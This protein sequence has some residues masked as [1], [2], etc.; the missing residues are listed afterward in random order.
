MKTFWLAAMLVT[1]GCSREDLYAQSTFTENVSAAYADCNESE[2][3]FL[4]GKHNIQTAFGRC[5]SN[6]FIDTA[7]SPDGSK[8]H[9]RVTNGSFILNADDK[10]ISTVPTEVPTADSAWLHADL[11]AMPLIPEEG[12]A[13]DEMRMA[14]YNLSANTLN[15]V[16]LPATK[17][18]DVQA[19]GDGKQLLMLATTTEDSVMRPYRFDP[20]TSELVRVFEFITAP[21]ERLEYAPKADLLAWSS[22]GTTELM[23]A[24]GTSVKLL[25]DV[26]RAVPH[27]EGRYVML[28]VLGEPISLF[29]Q[30]AWNELSPEARERELARQQKFLESL[31]DWAPREY[32]PPELH[33]LDL[34]DGSR[35]RITAFYGD[36]MEWYPSSNPMARYWISFMLWGIEGKQLNRNVGL[37][38]MA[39][40]FRMIDK[41]EVPLGI[42]V[43]GV[44]SASPAP[45]TESP[46]IQ[47]ETGD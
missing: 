10:T 15:L 17:V 6:N 31:P 41:G 18:K 29:D 1:A 2:I 42:E 34:E 7:W 3:R 37:S 9:F 30:R 35:H 20:D 39:E 46:A 45:G 12:K 25:E 36:H 27:P 28:E 33:I 5:G 23:R 21:V 38:D 11:V 22:E 43:V 24:D 32:T 13:S 8:L 19:W 44:S 26:L 14:L 4:T 16:G 40:R 47:D